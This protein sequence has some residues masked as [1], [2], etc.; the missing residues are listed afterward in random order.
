MPVSTQLAFLLRN[1]PPKY[2]TRAA[3]DFGAL[4]RSALALH[5]RGEGVSEGE[6]GEP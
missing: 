6:A 1:L 3:E 5:D 2:S 4:L